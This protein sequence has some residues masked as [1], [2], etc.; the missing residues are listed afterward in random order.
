MVSQPWED[1]QLVFVGGLHR[2]GTTVLA[3]MIASA[4]SASGLENTGVMMDEG[5]FLQDVYPLGQKHQPG[6]LVG[7]VARWA[8]DPRAH[9]L[10]GD[11]PEPGVLA[12][13]LW[14]SWSPYWNL[15]SHYLIEKSP[16]N[17]LKPLFLQEIFPTASFV[18]ITRHP[19]TQALA[20]RKWADIRSGRIT[21]G[22]PRIVENWVHAHELLR[23]DLTQVRRATIV[24]YEQLVTDPRSVAEH[25]E[26]FVGLDP[27]SISREGLSAA[28]AS[29]YE[30]EWSSTSPLLWPSRI[31]K[32]FSRAGRRPWTALDDSARIVLDTILLPRYKRVLRARFEDRV[33]RLGYDI[34]SFDRHLE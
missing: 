21:A 31:G 10:T 25:L 30:E 1:H 9:M 17:M 13:R 27:G 14:D 11:A 20:V 12:R 24:Q 23:A 6:G 2:S 32:A 26:E 16:A 3:E 8:M 22:L 7:G 29:E 4:R 28:R 5:Q 34:T 33:R 15:T 18:F 19:V